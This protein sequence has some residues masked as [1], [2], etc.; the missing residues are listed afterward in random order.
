MEA[1]KQSPII[2]KERFD[3]IYGQPGRSH[4]MSTAIWG[5]H[6]ADVLLQSKKMG[7]WEVDIRPSIIQRDL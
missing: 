6:S 1:L 7:Q 5:P 2:V 3:A 4:A